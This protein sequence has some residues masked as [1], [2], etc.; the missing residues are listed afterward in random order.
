MICFG[1][2]KDGMPPSLPAP[3]L[4]WQRSLGLLSASIP[5]PPSHPF[6]PPAWY[7]LRL[8]PPHM[9]VRTCACARTWPQ[10]HVLD[11]AHP[12]SS[13]PR[14]VQ[15]RTAGL[16]YFVE[17]HRP[18]RTRARTS[19]DTSHQ[20]R[21]RQQQQQQRGKGAEDGVGTSGVEASSNGAFRG[22]AGGSGSAN[23][24]AAEEGEGEEGQLVILTSAHI[25]SS[26]CQ[27]EVQ[28]YGFGGG[29]GS[30]RGDGGGAVIGGEVRELTVV[31]ASLS[32][33][34]LPYWRPLLPCRPGVVVTD[35]DMFA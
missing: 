14:L 33:P 25:R 9:H 17:H 29:G 3:S 2:M 8:I 31:T 22:Q 16:E 15:P 10:V 6:S 7:S 11:A 20:Q 26:S 4:L 19:T 28:G 13:P 27:V 5:S 30:G 34:G 35:M 18:T 21:G 23:L 1:I 12:G 32:Q 24:E